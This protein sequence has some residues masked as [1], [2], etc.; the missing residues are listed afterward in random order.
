MGTFDMLR[1][2]LEQVERVESISMADVI[3]LPD[4]LRRAM[5]A[6]VRRGAFT[7]SDL[8]A[9]LELEA[10]QA[11]ELTNLL[12]Q[13]GFVRLDPSS[14]DHQLTYRISLG[15]LRGRNVPLDLL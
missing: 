1:T 13:K 4:P 10:A 2:E 5:T 14:A 8:G 7:A 3:A 11:E 6:F 15:R 12:L 9:A